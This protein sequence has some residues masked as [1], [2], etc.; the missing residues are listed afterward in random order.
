MMD[1]KD[2]SHAGGDAGAFH[3]RRT[4]ERPLAGGRRFMPTRTLMIVEFAPQY[5]N[6]SS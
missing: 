6:R 2:E 4:P 3:P 1:A 5:V